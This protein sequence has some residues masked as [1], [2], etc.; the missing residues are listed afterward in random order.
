MVTFVSETEMDKQGNPKPSKRK[1]IILSPQSIGELSMAAEDPAE[2]AKWKATNT[3]AEKAEGRAIAAEG[4]A[5]AGEKRTAAKH[6]AALRKTEAEATTA[7]AKA[8]LSSEQALATLRATQRSK[9]GDSPTAWKGVDRRSLSSS[10]T[11]HIKN[12]VD[13]GT[14]EVYQLYEESGN[15]IGSYMNDL[16]N[17]MKTSNT[18]ALAIIAEKLVQYPGAQIAQDPKSGRVFAVIDGRQISLD[19]I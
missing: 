4:R 17:A 16:G 14:K 12:R 18:E 9:A 8:E 10:V 7:E 3:R 15:R 19:K 13:T 1:P 6:P 11:R 5:V 2:F